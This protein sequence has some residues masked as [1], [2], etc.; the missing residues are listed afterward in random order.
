MHRDLAT[1]FAEDKE[2]EVDEFCLQLS[3]THYSLYKAENQTSIAATHKEDGFN[4]RT[5]E[6][7]KI[8]EGINT[9]CH[10]ESKHN[11]STIFYS[12]EVHYIKE[13]QND[14]QEDPFMNFGDQFFYDASI[15]HNM[16]Q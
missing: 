15:C 1:K 4:P 16:P 6:I 12:D 5:Q 9:H 10:N 13:D 7:I 8:V 3:M 14:Q 11:V 2:R